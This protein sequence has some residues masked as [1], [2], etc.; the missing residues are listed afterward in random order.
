MRDVVVGSMVGGLIICALSYAAVAQ[1]ASERYP[2]RSPRFCLLSHAC[3]GRYAPPKGADMNQ[4]YR[5]G[6]PAARG[7]PGL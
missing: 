6:R 4:A 5:A 7:G 2:D 1:S 3:S